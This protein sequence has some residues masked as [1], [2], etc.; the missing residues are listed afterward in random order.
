MKFNTS[1]L[2]FGAISAA[3]TLG[4]ALTLD[5]NDAIACSPAPP[6]IRLEHTLED[7]QI[8]TR[9]PVI[10]FGSS[11]ATPTSADKFTLTD[12][13]G[14]VYPVTTAKVMTPLFWVWSTVEPENPLPA[15]NYTLVYETEDPTIAPAPGSPPPT[16]KKTLT[17]E[18]STSAMHPD[19]FELGLEWSRARL[20]P[21]DFPLMDSCG[22]SNEESQQLALS[23]G[24]S[25]RTH[26][27][28]VRYAIE[29]TDATGQY[30][31]GQLREVSQEDISAAMS[32]DALVRTIANVSMQGS[33]LAD[34]V[35][36][37][38]FTTSGVR[39]DTVEL[40]TPTRCAQG[41]G[42]PD[43][44]DAFSDCE[45]S[46]GQVTEIKLADPYPA[47]ACMLTSGFDPCEGVVCADGEM[48]DAGECVAIDLCENVICL[49]TQECIDGDCVD[50]DPCADV[51]CEGNQ[52]CVDGA[53]VVDDPCEGVMCA[54]G[55]S[56]VEGACEQDPVTDACADV[57]CAEG[58]MCV[59]GECKDEPAADACADVTCEADQICFD[60]KCYAEVT[61]NNMTPG[62]DNNG[63]GTNGEGTPDDMMNQGGG[64]DG[65]S[66]SA[67]DSGCQAVGSSPIDGSLAGLALLGM[68]GLMRRR[69]RA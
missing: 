58:Q 40:C 50:I 3:A 7:G 66:E 21:D 29:F 42:I 12:D 69:K 39:G 27:A 38:P 26:D 56:C 49:D 37:T 20:G 8:T 2:L 32:S 1:A 10:L 60:G 55:E 18:V 23:F 13:Q 15:G 52:S 57:T 25:C 5:V 11:D 61:P 30:L 62:G 17:F 4:A 14:T 47:A 43:N 63:S 45:G 16:Y 53:C 59:E 22:G 9:Q 46:A 6:E 24:A 35:R 64:D 54:E 19:A 41:S 68:V 33:K 31:Y 48:C 34:C 65:D 28:G 44:A 51:I 67:D 36:V